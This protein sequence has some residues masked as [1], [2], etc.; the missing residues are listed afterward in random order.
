M[1]SNFTKVHRTFNEQNGSSENTQCLIHLLNTCCLGCFFLQVT[2]KN[3]NLGAHVLAHNHSALMLYL[4]FK[5]MLQHTE[6]LY[7]YTKSLNVALSTVIHYIFPHK[8]MSYNFYWNQ[9][10]LNFG[11]WAC[12]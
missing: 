3:N 8:S 6:Y 1:I 7:T 2:L 12:S 11:S 5:T 10:L 9:F 4:I